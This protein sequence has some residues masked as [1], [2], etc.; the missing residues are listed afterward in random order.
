MYA[1]CYENDIWRSY[2]QYKM[3]GKQVKVYTQQLAGKSEGI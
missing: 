1:G 2:N 3:M